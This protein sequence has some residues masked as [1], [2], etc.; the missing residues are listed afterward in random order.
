MLIVLAMSK[1]K[2]KMP[3]NH[4]G[5][6]RLRFPAMPRPVTIPMRAH[7]I[8][9]AAMSGQVSRAVQR[10]AVPSCAPATE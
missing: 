6:R 1:D 5:N 4:F 3:N 10:S 9:T 8:C 7:I 2:T